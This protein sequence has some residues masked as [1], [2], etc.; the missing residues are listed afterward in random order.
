MARKVR[1]L[2]L[3]P[4]I[5]LFSMGTQL[6]AFEAILSLALNGQDAGSQHLDNH[7]GHEQEHSHGQGDERQSHGYTAPVA[8]L[9][10]VAPSTVQLASLLA[11]GTQGLRIEFARKFRPFSRVMSRSAA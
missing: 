2:T 4:L 8:L 7:V 6:G 5:A 1:A 9:Q 11:V 3:I 10:Q